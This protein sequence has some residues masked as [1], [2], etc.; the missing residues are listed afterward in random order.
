MGE[1]TRVPIA[2]KKNYVKAFGIE[3]RCMGGKIPARGVVIDESS[4]SSGEPNNW[5]RGIGERQAVRRLL[6]HTVSSYFRGAPVFF[7]NCF[8]LGPW[9]TGMNVAMGLADTTILKCLGPEKGKIESTLRLFGPGHCYVLAGYPP[10]IK[11]WLDS[12]RLDLSSYNLHLLVG[13]EA[14]SEALRDRFLR[15]FK[16]VHS[17][18]GA[19]DLEIN[20]GAETEFT[21]ALRR[22]LRD[23][24]DL[25]RELFG[26]DSLPMLFQYNPFDYFVEQSPEGEILVTLLRA[27]VASPKVR[28]NI[29]DRGGAMSMRE[30]E[31]RLRAAGADLDLFPPAP[32]LP[33]LWVG[34]RSDLSVPFYGSKVFTTDLDTLLNEDPELKE[35]FTSFQLRADQ[36]ADLNERLIVRLERRPGPDVS[37][38][39]AQVRGVVFEGL[40]RVNQDFREVSGGLPPDRFEV[41]VH[42]HAQ[43]P[44]AHKDLRVKLRYLDPVPG[45]TGALPSAS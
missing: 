4:G 20:I 44:F 37:T 39:P 34:A 12:T 24:P 45:P 27:S 36:D 19:S 17:S 38:A 32:A 35:A 41:E 31:G 6:E 10:F 42:G 23:K 25:R 30:L 33:L 28:Y 13:G 43:G 29:R 1:W 22:W 3:E 26:S 21:I 5:V 40:R 2:D 14:L 18:Y 15:V 7:L 8:A 9:A 11:D 16:T